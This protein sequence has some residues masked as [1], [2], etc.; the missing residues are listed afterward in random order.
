MA[1][2]GY[3]QCT[4]MNLAIPLGSV[5][6]I[7]TQDVSWP[8]KIALW[9]ASVFVPSN[10]EGDIFDIVYAPDTPI[11]TVASVVNVGDTV[12]SVSPTVTASVVP[13][14][15]VSL[16]DSTHRNDL[17]R[18]IALDTINKTITMETPT[19]NS[20]DFGTTV[21][22]NIKF[23]RSFVI[24]QNMTSEITL[25]SGWIKS[26]VIPP[27]THLRVIYTNTTG[28]AKSISMK[29]EYHIMT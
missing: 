1:P 3:Y 6:S 2:E 25:G 19:I 8:M 21:D 28:T 29:M 22:L 18:V 9:T 16:L 17:N 10:S 15:D 20:F 24:G 7:Y 14:F 13:G 26:M 11:G 23:I 12:I 27:N 5:G 4:T